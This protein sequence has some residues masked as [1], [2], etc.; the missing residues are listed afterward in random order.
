DGLNLLAG[1]TYQLQG[2]IEKLDDGLVTALQVRQ[3]NLITKSHKHNLLVLGQWPL[4]GLVALSIQQF[5]SHWLTR[6]PFGT[7]W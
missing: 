5:G 3:T 2:C 6:A 7:F 1:R 4:A